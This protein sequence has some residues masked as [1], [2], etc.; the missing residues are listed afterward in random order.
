MTKVRA[1]FMSFGNFRNGLRDPKNRK[2]LGKTRLYRCK[3]PM[4]TQ[5]RFFKAK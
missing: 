5:Y 3:K 2:N 1:F 4:N